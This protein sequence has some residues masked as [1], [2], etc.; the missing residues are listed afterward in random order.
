[1]DPEVAL[2]KDVVV[3]KAVAEV[4]EIMAAAAVAGDFEEIVAEIVVVD[5]AVA[6]VEEIMAA[7]AVAGDFEE[8]VAEIVVVDFAEEDAEAQVQWKSFRECI[9]ACSIHY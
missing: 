6:E 4:E 5:K 8:I 2:V 7:T 1:V 3:D 9:T